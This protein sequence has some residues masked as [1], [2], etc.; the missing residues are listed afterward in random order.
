MRLQSL[1]PLLTESEILFLARERLQFSG[2]MEDVQN[3]ASGQFRTSVAAPS[4][5]NFLSATCASYPANS[6]QTLG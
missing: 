6:G 2:R 4:A 1:T 3:F 5:S